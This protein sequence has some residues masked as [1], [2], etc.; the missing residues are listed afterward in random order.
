MKYEFTIEANTKSVECADSAEIS[1]FVYAPTVFDA[2][3]QIKEWMSNGKNAQF[4]TD[5]TYINIVLPAEDSSDTIEISDIR[6]FSD[7]INV[8]SDAVDELLHANENNC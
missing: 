2:I 1:G 6:Y 5:V 8:T 7:G 3:A 4:Y